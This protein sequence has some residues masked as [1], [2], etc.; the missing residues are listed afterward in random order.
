M[1]P[2]DQTGLYKLNWNLLI[3]ASSW[4]MLA[5]RLR[6][7]NPT[8]EVEMGATE[9]FLRDIRRRYLQRAGPSGLLIA[10]SSICFFSFCY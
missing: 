10:T 5:S 6:A 3:N 8:D 9:T 7:E 4:R 1:Q 2:R